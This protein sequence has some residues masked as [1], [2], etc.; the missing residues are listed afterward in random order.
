MAILA[1][2][3]PENVI[4]MEA[5]NSFAKF[6]FRP[7][8]PGYGITI[9]NALRRI[10]LSSLEGYAISSIKIEGVNHE[11]ATIPGV[12][13]DVTNIILNLKQVRFSSI[14]SGTDEETVTLEVGG[15]KTEFLAGDLSAK[16]SHFQVLNPELVICHI[17]EEKS[18][19]ITVT[20]DK[21]RGYVPADEKH[22]K[23][24]DV[25]VLA[26]DSTYTIVLSEVLHIADRR[27]DRVNS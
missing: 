24:D 8:E 6:E 13:E 1:F 26:I 2:Q 25:Q 9:G 22:G 4:M 7:L 27:V 15:G 10:L 12:L 17:D 5:T 14:A 19:S 18:F 11:F 3:R 23:Y 16:L 21:G 20:I